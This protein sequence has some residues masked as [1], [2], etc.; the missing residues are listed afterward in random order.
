MV[1]P[2]CFI[3]LQKFKS[4]HKIYNAINLATTAFEL[5]SPAENEKLLG[6]L[7]TFR[8]LTSLLVEIF[9]PELEAVSLPDLV[10][11][12]VLIAF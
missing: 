9:L 7:S 11:H 12:D 3:E 1:L 5:N 6:F 4:C 10:E 8:K 2:F